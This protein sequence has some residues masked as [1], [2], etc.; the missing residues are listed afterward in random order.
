VLRRIGEKAATFGTGLAIK[1]SIDYGF[2]YLLYPVVLLWFG[3]LWGGIIM[4]GLSVA[5]NLAVIRV[6]DWSK[7]DWL[8][9]E[10]IKELR[11]GPDGLAKTPWARWI[12]RKG[13]LPAFFLLSW[14]EDPIVV[15]L[16]L[17]RSAHRYDGL[18]RRDW[19]IFW[20]ST[21]VS[22]LLWML[23]LVSAIELVRI[24]ARLLGL[25]DWT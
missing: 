16:Y 12:A 13:D 14:F 5:L 6:Y 4:T 25:A 20:A 23:S 9:L 18:D 3:Y 7:R 2:D 15:T 19:L 21:L 1:K 8:L 17:R 22:N 24:G 10:T 11:D